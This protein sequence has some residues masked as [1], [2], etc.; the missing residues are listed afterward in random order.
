[1]MSRPLCSSGT[2]NTPTL[3]C[4]WWGLTVPQCY[5]GHGEGETP[6]PIPNPEAKPFSADGTAPGTVWESRTQPDN[7]SQQRA[8]QQPRWALSCT[9][10]SCSH[11]AHSSS[12]DRRADGANGGTSCGRVLKPSVCCPASDPRGKPAASDPTRSV[13]PPP[14]CPRPMIEEL[15]G[16]T[17]ES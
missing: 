9:R 17:D 3:R 11:R 1:M 10:S 4:V 12:P 16:V 6:G 8:H 5:G 2:T 7:H 13:R 15:S 14:W